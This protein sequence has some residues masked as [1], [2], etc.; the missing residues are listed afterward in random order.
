M[1]E[2]FIDRTLNRDLRQC[3]AIR[4]SAETN[5]H[6]ERNPRTIDSASNALDMRYYPKSSEIEGCASINAVV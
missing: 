5:I 3:S 6:V 4:T 2:E 1:V